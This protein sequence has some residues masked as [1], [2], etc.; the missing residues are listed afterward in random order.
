MG[1]P[2]YFM[3]QF[4]YTDKNHH[5]EPTAFRG[6][7][8]RG[9]LKRLGAGALAAGLPWTASETAAA[10]S[11][12]IP[13]PQV[14][15][16][17]P[18]VTIAGVTIPRMIVGSNPISGFSHQ[19]H[20]MTL[21]YLDYFNQENT[22]LFLKR[23]EEAGLTLWLMQNE[24]KTRAAI[25]ARWAA[26][27][28]MRVYFLGRLDAQGKLS[29]DILEYKPAFYIHHGNV[30]D[31]LFKNGKQELVHDFVKRVHDE[32]GI[33]AGVSAHNPDCIKYIEDKGWEVDLYQCCLYYV[34]RPKDEIQAKLGGAPLGESFLD[35]DR[36]HML[37]LVQEVKKPCIVFKILG[38]G[39]HCNND[40]AVENAFR[41]TLERIKKTDAFL[42]GMWPKFKDEISQNVRLTQKYGQ[43]G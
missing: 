22:T 9:F 12:I 16:P 29:K 11:E 18:Q 3:S 15:G 32:L 38:A 4:T 30:T 36:D 35:T 19:I 39:W 43:I 17:I 23:C 14:S 7:D 42:V 27:S 2:V 31:T 24:D 8:R 10:S 20:N 1:I 6:Q 37:K 21:A 25:K 41:Y 33:P 34:T 40:S 26:G 28:K 5:P 13:P